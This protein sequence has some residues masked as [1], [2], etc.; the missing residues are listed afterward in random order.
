MFSSRGLCHSPLISIAPP[1][2]QL[3]D[4]LMSTY[5]EEKERLTAVAEQLAVSNKLLQAELAD[6]RQLVEEC[7]REIRATVE[8]VNQAK[9]LTLAMAAEQQPPSD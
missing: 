7:E 6:R 3:R 5:T 4:E 2:E 8:L 9:V 1:E